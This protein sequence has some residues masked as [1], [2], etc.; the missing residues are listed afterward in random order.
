MNTCAMIAAGVG[1]YVPLMAVAIEIA[2]LMFLLFSY[3]FKAGDAPPPEKTPKEERAQTRVLDIVAMLPAACGLG[4]GVF[5]VFAGWPEGAVQWTCLV[6]GCLGC[7]LFCI[8]FGY[9]FLFG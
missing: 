2:W 9:E 4:I 7:G 8:S 5:G 1:P 3:L 6:I